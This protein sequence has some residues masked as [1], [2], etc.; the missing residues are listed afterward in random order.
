MAGGTGD[1][2]VRHG[3]S[4][5]SGD[6]HDELVRAAEVLRA[7]GVVAFP[8][9]TVYGLGADAERDEA[10]RRVFAI[11][12]RPAGHPLIVH[13]ADPEAL[14]RWASDVPDAASRLAAAFW[15]GPLTLILRKRPRIADAATGGLATVGL[16]V[17]AHPLAR[18][19]LVEFGGAIAAPS[20]NRF[21]SVSPTTAAHV[22]E[23]L[24]GDVDVVLDGGSCEVGVESTI[25]DLSGTEVRLLRPGGITLEQLETTLGWRVAVGATADV[26]APG[27]LA[28]HYAPRAEVQLAKSDDLAA[29]AARALERGVRV[30]VLTIGPPPALPPGVESIALEQPLEA[31]ARGL[32]AALR[33]A[34]RRGLALLLAA[35]PDELGLGRAVADRLRRAAGPR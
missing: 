29:H 32:Y 28:S 8:T 4:Q 21:G 19:L 15:P 22:R 16:R 31:A 5:L 1:R 3:R 11:K 35:L 12:G 10:V 2:R 17:P 27:L 9:E 25:V 13:F 18:A 14:D 34:D 20:A 7:G 24:G 23:D 6:R 33:E 30:G 26:R